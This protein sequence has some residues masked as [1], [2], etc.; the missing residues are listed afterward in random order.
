[1]YKIL[2]PT[3]QPFCLLRIRKHPLYPRPA[4]RHD[5]IQRQLVPLGG[6]SL[7]LQHYLLQSLVA[8]LCSQE[9]LIKLL[10]NMLQFRQSRIDPLLDRI[11]MQ[12]QFLHLPRHLALIHACLL[13]NL[14][15]YGGIQL[16]RG[17]SWRA[18]LRHQQK[19]F[20]QDLGVC[21]LQVHLGPVEAHGEV[22]QRGRD[23]VVQTLYRKVIVFPPH[24]FH[25][26]ALLCELREELC[27]LVD[28]LGE[29][30]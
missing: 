30:L 4:Q 17:R 23:A 10:V 22:L 14:G 15:E 18:G 24:H 6:L 21:H 29:L 13:R 8:L 9:L 2:S 3:G 28:S 12:A 25:Q 20:I 5:M 26:K 11:Q 7:P 27:A 16:V 19:H 1:M